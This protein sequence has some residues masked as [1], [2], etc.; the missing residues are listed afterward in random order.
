MRWSI[1][2]RFLPKLFPAG[3]V[4]RDGVAPGSFRGARM[5]DV[6]AISDDLAEEMAAAFEAAL[7]GGE[8][9]KVIDA[10][11]AKIAEVMASSK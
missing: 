1:L 9:D 10:L 4:P 3:A 8:L 5:N 11:A 7:Q 2:R 6:H